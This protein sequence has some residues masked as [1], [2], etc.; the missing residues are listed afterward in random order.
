YISS[1]VKSFTIGTAVGMGYVNHPAGVTKELLES[2]RWEIEIAGKLY[3][4]DASL[5]AF[6]DPNGDRAKQ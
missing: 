1:G 4:S 2:S 6:F 5:R 3:E